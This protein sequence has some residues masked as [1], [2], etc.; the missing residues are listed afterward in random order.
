MI[1]LSLSSYFIPSIKILHND[2][3]QALADLNPKKAYEPDEIPSVV[4]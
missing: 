3:F 2:V 1:H 4:L